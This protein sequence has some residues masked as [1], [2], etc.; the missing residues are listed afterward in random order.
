MAKDSDKPNVEHDQEKK[1]PSSRDALEEAKAKSEQAVLQL[2][3]N[4]GVLYDQL[5]A[6]RKQRD[7]ENAV[8]IGIRFALE[9]M[10]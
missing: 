3:A 9:K 10:E 4:I 7:N 6:L 8:L 2:S 5:E 1:A